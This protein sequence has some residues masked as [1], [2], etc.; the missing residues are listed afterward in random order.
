MGARCKGPDTPVR[1]VMTVEV[2]C[3]SEDEDL[4]RVARTMGEQQLR[5]LPVVSRD[6]RRLVGIL[7][8]GDVATGAG[9]RPAG[10]ALARVSRPGG[11]HTQA[12]APPT[13]AGA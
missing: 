2:R 11:P 5:R 4:Q 1:E 8:L 12:G 10:E 7:S 9:P 13:G 6:G 3:C